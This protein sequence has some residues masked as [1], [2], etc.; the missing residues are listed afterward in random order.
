MLVSTAKN[1][2]NNVVTE[3]YFQMSA[4]IRRITSMIIM[5]MSTNFCIRSD[6][7]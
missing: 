7:A 4:S 3:V 6:I 2:G 5:T 1:L